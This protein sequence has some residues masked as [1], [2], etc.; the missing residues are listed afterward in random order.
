M[1]IQTQEGT[2]TQKIT[3]HKKRKSTNQI[4]ANKRKKESVLLTGLNKSQT[5]PK[6]LQKDQHKSDRSDIANFISLGS[7]IELPLLQL[8]THDASP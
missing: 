5:C 3:L 7:C 1:T 8:L 2:I 6:L 4:K